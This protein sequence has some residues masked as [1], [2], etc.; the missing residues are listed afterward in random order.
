MIDDKI[1]LKDIVDLYRRTPLMAFLYFCNELD[2]ERKV[3]DCGAGAQVPPLALFKMHGYDTQGIDISEKKLE[4]ARNFEKKHGIKLNI[5][6]G[7]M[8]KM[9][10]E[11]ESFSF[12]YSYNTVFHMKKK[13]VY[14]SIGEMARVLRPNGLVF[15]NLLSL[16]DG[17]Y[18]KGEE[19]DPDEFEET[20]NEKKVIHSYFDNDEADDHLVGMRVFAKQKRVGTIESKEGPMNYAFMDYYLKKSTK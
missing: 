10:F 9:D 7:D 13:E 2:M 3:L 6:I 15:F 5:G 12:V 16:D 18:G 19:L 4:L 11:D 20:F 8:R 17:G 14:S 1:F